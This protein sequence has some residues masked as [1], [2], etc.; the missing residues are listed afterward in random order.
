MA[1]TAL[2]VEILVSGLLAMAWIVGVPLMLLFPEMFGRGLSNFKEFSG[3]SVLLGLLVLAVAYPLG[4]LVNFFTYAVAKWTYRK[5]LLREVFGRDVTSDTYHKLKALIVMQ[6][7]CDEIVRILNNNV[8]VHRL[9][10]AGGFNFI[11]IGLI[12]LFLSEESEGVFV[13]SV[14]L[15]LGLSFCLLAIQ[16]HRVSFIWLR[17]AAAQFPEGQE[18]L[19]T[20]QEKTIREIESGGVKESKVGA[21]NPV[22]QADS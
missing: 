12:L 5:T 17:Y 20:C 18:L 16:K 4:W 1:T 13:G 9:A 19:A 8:S 6:K 15:S 7:D 2:V 22:A 3:Y 11:I 21:P 14:L 10:R